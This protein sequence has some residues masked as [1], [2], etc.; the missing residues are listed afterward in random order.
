MVVGFYGF[1]WARWAE[2]LARVG[3]DT[4]SFFCPN[5]WDQRDPTFLIGSYL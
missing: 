1:S 3:G 5:Q 2:L 4:L